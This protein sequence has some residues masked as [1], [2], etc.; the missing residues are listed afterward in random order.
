MRIYYS[1]KARE[2]LHDAPHDVQDR[3]EE[4]ML[5]FAAQDNPLSFAKFVKEKEAHRFRIGDYRLLFTLKDNLISIVKIERR[6]KAY[7]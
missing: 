5:F 4:K 7:D 6:D 2:W 3:I 1:Y